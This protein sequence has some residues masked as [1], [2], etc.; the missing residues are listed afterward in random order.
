MLMGSEDFVQAQQPQHV[1]TP[2]AQ[3]T[4]CFSVFHRPQCPVTTCMRTNH[5]A[6]LKLPT[7]PATKA[8]LP[9]GFLPLLL[10]RPSEWAMGW[11]EE[12][13]AEWR[14]LMSTERK[15]GKAARAGLVD[16]GVHAGGDLQASCGSGCA[17]KLDCAA[18]GHLDPASAL[19]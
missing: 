5:A 6:Y 11:D 1:L 7:S 18:L 10:G 19:S 4:C 14:A 3:A 16:G 12:A 13:G 8:A 2:E 9:A 15:A 17:Q